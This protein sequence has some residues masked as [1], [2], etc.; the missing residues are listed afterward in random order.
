KDGVVSLRYSNGQPCLSVKDGT[1]STL[2]TFTCKLGGL[3]EPVF[4]G[5][6]DECTYQFVWETELMCAQ[7]QAEM[8]PGDGCKVFDPETSTNYDLSPLQSQTGYPVTTH[9]THHTY[10]LNVCAPVND[11]SCG[12]GAG[13][14]EKDTKTSLG[15]PA[16]ALSMVNGV[17]TLS[18]TGGAKCP[19][20]GV[21]SR[22]KE[23]IISFVCE[24]GV[25][26]GNG[27]PV[28]LNS[29]DEC[30]YL[31]EWRTPLACSSATKE[32]M[33]NVVVE[34]AYEDV[35]YDLSPL[36]RADD[37]WQAIVSGQTET[38]TYV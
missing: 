15:K 31:F 3:G 22:Q 37:D 28:A 17:L 35:E 29:P 8:S 20:S 34:N 23:S 14:C 32:T 7:K 13:V 4:V 30:T 5:E 16:G 33:C 10:T 2:I 6:T 25:V 18:Y 26:V 38:W 9:N 24:E 12:D 11:P 1:T 27:F 21:S 19:T 36:T